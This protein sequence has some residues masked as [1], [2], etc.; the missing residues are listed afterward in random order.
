MSTEII[1]S[2]HYR[3]THFGIR[4]FVALNRLWMFRAHAP[5]NS[6][7][8]SCNGGSFSPSDFVVNAGE[9]C[10]EALRRCF[11]EN[12]KRQKESDEAIAE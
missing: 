7:T 2:G 6:D 10:T 12:A 8:F 4:Y 3:A 5:V 1:S 9:S 11:A